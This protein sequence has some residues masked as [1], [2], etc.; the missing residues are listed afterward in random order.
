MK[1]PRKHG[2]SRLEVCLEKSI[3]QELKIQGLREQLMT[4]SLRIAVLENNSQTIINNSSSH[5]R[6]V[7]GQELKPGQSMV[8]PW[9]QRLVV[10]TVRGGGSGLDRNKP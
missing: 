8:V 1:K 5:K 6:Y 3:S 10:E 4:L 9:D 2:K 7:N